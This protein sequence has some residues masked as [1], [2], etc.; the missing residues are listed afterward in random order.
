[1]V[2]SPEIFVTSLLLSKARARGRGALESLQVAQLRIRCALALT[3]GAPKF[4]KHFPLILGHIFT[5]RGRIECPRG[6]LA[7][8]EH[9]GE[10]VPFFG[11]GQ[12]CE[13]MS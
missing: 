1:M 3:A 4:A 11:P 9:A 8:S 5:F 6:R 7:F 10:R 2:V 12:E 13:R